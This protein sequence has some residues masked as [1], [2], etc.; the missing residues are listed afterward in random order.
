M[1]KKKSAYWKK[2]YV[3]SEIDFTNNNIFNLNLNH[4]KMKKG[5]LVILA[6]ASMATLNSCGKKKG[7]SAETKQAMATFES[8][9]KALGDQIAAWE[10]TMNTAMDGMTQMMTATRSMDITKLSGESKSMAEMNLMMC[11]KIDEQMVAMKT[12]FAKA[13]TDFAAATDEYGAWKK[14]GQEEHL[15]DATITSELANWTTKLTEWKT[16]VEGLNQ[17]LSGMQDACKQSCDAITAMVP[18]K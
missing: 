4:N 15:D 5:F 2:A 16:T 6:I 3:T 7:P 11:S 17:Q 18:A 9:W 14:K 10:T 1:L 8:E 13:K 12:G